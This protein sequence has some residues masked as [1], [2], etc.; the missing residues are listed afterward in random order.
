MSSSRMRNENLI[1]VQIYVFYPT[2][3]QKIVVSYIDSMRVENS[4]ISYCF[5]L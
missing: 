1:I 4:I 3:G 2:F 5:S